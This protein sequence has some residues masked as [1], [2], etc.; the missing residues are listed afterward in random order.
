LFLF[1]SWLFHQARPYRGTGLRISVA[2]NL[3]VAV[4]E[5]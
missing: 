4:P 2:F 3:G 5:A 1:P